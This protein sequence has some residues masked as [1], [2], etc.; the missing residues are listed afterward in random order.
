MFLK[1]EKPPGDMAGLNAWLSDA[2]RFRRRS[3]ALISMAEG[4]TDGLKE[5][6]NHACKDAYW[7]VRMAAAACEF[8][9]PGTLSADN[10]ALLK[11]DHVY[12]VQALFRMPAGA[13]RLVELDPAKLENLRR[14]RQKSD[15][16]VKPEGPDDFLICFRALGFIRK[17]NTC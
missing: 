4:N 8:L 16:K 17:P 12:W 11:K 7:Q 14:F 9:H 3:A 1:D 13:S 2:G 5:A 6:A 15:P 10:M